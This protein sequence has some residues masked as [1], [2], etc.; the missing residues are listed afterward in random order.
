MDCYF[1]W[2][3]NF[4]RQKK[5]IALHIPLSLFHLFIFLHYCNHKRILCGWLLGNFRHIDS[6]TTVHKWYESTCDCH[7]FYKIYIQIP[8]YFPWVYAFRKF[9]DKIVITTEPI[10]ARNLFYRKMDIVCLDEIIN[11]KCKR[12]F[13]NKR[14]AMCTYV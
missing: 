4:Y 11:N 13:C 8:L 3:N 10:N 7:M 12:Q 1:A 2:Q 14:H 9:I 6:F 5:N